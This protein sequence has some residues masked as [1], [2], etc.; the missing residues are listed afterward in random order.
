MARNL[1]WSAPI[2]DCTNFCH[3]WI[4]T[5]PDFIPLKRILAKHYVD[6][7]MRSN[8]APE[9]VQFSL[10]F[11][12]ELIANKGNREP[13]DFY[14][15]SKI[16]SWLAHCNNKQEY[17]DYA[18]K[19]LED[20][21]KLYPD[22]WQFHS[23]LATLFTQQSKFDKALKEAFEA[24][25]KAPW[26]ETIYNLISSIYNFMGDITNAENYKQESEAL[27]ERKQELYK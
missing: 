2:D 14:Y 4:E 9:Y 17:I 19:L 22:Y 3:K 6:E 26:R 12:C 25:R 10:D 27:K 11:F 7:Y 24:K 5:Y 23:E 21:I 8:S 18:F 13:V 1:F 16:Y 20:G 15:L